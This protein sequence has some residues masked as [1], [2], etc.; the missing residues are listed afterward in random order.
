MSE[1]YV[2]IEAGPGPGQFRELCLSD[3]WAALELLQK[4][5]RDGTRLVA[6]SLRGDG[7]SIVNCSAGNVTGRAYACSRDAESLK[8]DV[9][10]LLGL[11]LFF[12]FGV[13]SSLRDAYVAA[14]GNDSVS[15]NGLSNDV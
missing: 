13:G 12:R 8:D 6:N 5:L 1:I 2:I 3:D 11:D 10:S 7:F 9:V 14:F 4:R 15:T